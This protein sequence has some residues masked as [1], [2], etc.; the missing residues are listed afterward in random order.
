MSRRYPK[1]YFYNKVKRGDKLDHNAHFIFCD[2]AVLCVFQIEFDNYKFAEEICSVGL[3]FIIFYGGFGTKWSEAKKVAGKSLIL[4]SAGVLLTA[5]ATG[6]FCKLVLGF[7]WLESLL[8]GAV[9]SSTCDTV[10]LQYWS[11]KA[12]ATTLGLI[13]SRL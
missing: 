12:E 9:I 5:F 2:S 7:E 10:R 11:L 8:I 4:A 1:R 13:C 3:V 6:A